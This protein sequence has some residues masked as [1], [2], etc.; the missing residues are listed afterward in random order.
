MLLLTLFTAAK[1]ATK[2]DGIYYNLNSN[3]TAKVTNRCNGCSTYSG[4]I[5]IPPSV[6]YDGKTYSVTSI[7]DFAFRGST[8]LTSVTIPESVT[9]IGWNAFRGCNLTSVTIE[10]GLTEIGACAF[11]ECDNL[12]NIILPA[13]LKRIDSQVF[14]YCT[15][16]ETIIIPA[17]VESMGEYVFAGCNAKVYMLPTTPPALYQTNGF[18]LIEA[19]IGDG[20]Y[21]VPCDAVNAYLSNDAWSTVN[22]IVAQ[23][24]PNA[25]IGCINYS[26]NCD[27]TA[28][29]T[30]KEEGYTGTVAIP[31]SVIFESLN[32]NVTNIG[33]SAFSGCTGLTSVTIP[34]SVTSIGNYAFSGCTGLTGVT[35][36]NSVT[37]IG[38]GAFSNIPY[39][40]Y[41]GSATGSP[42][43]AKAVYAAQDGY[44]LFKDAAKTNLVKCLPEAIGNIV[45]PESVTTISSNA[46]SGCTGITNIV[47]NAKNCISAPFSSISENITSFVF[48]DEVE[49]IP[50]GLCA[51]ME[52]IIS[53][54]IGNSVTSI[55]NY[56]FSGCTGLSS[57]KV[58]QG[59]T[60]Y[61]S[62]DNCNA[63][64]ETATNTLIAGCQSTVIP[65][66]VTSIGKRAFSGCTGLTGITI[67]N[68]VTSI[69][70]YAFSGC[71]GLQ[72]V[73]LGSGMKTIYYDAFRDC[74]SM[75][76]ITCY[77]MRPPTIINSNNQTN[78][79]F[80]TLPYSTIVYVPADYL[81]TYMMHDIWGLYDVRPL[82]AASVQTDNLL[83]T[84][85]YT[86][87][88]VAWPSVANAASYEITITSN[89][90]TVC[91]LTFNAQGQ[92]T[93]IAFRAPAAE[94]ARAAGQGFQFTVTGLED[95]SAYSLTLNAKDAVGNVLR[96]FSQDFS[97]GYTAI[98]E[99]FDD[100]VSLKPRKVLE[101]GRV[102]I[103]M[104]D[105]RKFDANGRKV[106]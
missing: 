90:I 16:L 52:N 95:G 28:E 33:E 47:W 66:S 34:I 100:G 79:P 19:A 42:W 76:S 85:H 71:T 99:A 91:T 37:S 21:I 43:G 93:N 38:S 15:S 94:P 14:E 105:G 17:S 29:V 96:T 86:T 27:G 78:K 50:N 55:G 54:T 80:E 45:I 7:G 48:G 65:N 30:S 24:Q 22:T 64:I 89:G 49:S 103:L 92:L 12:R 104:P 41:A 9:S 97:T 23:E 88:D 62:R 25:I 70:N 84:P 5:I 57:I 59:N 46:F 39:I 13:T 20:N 82:G 61:D 36:P 11:K 40:V 6:T 4:N 56:A 8:G 74:T 32:Y 26:L 44:L 67:P 35:I 102:I 75:Q 63:I 98:E 60:K 1:A 68:S 72:S 73:V 10:N 77:S 69:G 51:G 83:V 58:E 3:G 2:I 18:S 101:E 106:K 87:A 53:I 31:S 81:N